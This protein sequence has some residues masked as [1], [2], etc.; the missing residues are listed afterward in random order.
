MLFERML[1]A[2]CREDD[3]KEEY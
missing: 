3:N 1:V 2:V